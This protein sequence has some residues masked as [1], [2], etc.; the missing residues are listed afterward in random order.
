VSCPGLRAEPSSLTAPQKS[1]EG[2]VGPRARAEGLNGG[3]EE[4]PDVER[5]E[6][7]R[8]GVGALAPGVNSRLARRDP[9]LRLG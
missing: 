4:S 6:R 8:R 2:L 3:E 1:A 7:I 5:G 9:M